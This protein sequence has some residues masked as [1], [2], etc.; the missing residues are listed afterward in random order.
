MWRTW[1][2]NFSFENIDP[3]GFPSLNKKMQKGF[4]FFEFGKVML[5]CVV[6]LTLEALS[7]T[8]GE[9]GMLQPTQSVLLDPMHNKDALVSFFSTLKPFNSFAIFSYFTMKCHHHST[10]KNHFFLPFSL[11]CQFHIHSY[12]IHGC[13]QQ[14]FS[15]ILL[16]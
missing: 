10:P 8:S 3:S 4:E 7:A 15:L 1:W 12:Y 5:M 11:F 2:A 6:S 14:H 16:F 13:P 9:H